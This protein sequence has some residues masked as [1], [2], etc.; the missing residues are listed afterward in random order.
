VCIGENHLLSIALM[1][2][3]AGVVM[4]LVPGD[5]VVGVININVIASPFDFCSDAFAVSGGGIWKPFF[6]R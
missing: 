1:S 2:P 6:L 5:R 4:A 3:A